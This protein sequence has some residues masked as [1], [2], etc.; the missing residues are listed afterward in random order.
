MGQTRE[1]KEHGARSMGQGAWGKGLKGN[2]YVV[3][4]YRILVIMLL[5]T[6]CRAGFFVFNIGKFPGVGFSQF[7]GMERG[8]LMFDISAVVYINMLFI[9]LHLPP[10]DFRYNAAWQKI[11]KY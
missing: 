7:L 9:L 10:F 8:G 1:S 11:L 2:I 3:L 5:F 4:G 6:L